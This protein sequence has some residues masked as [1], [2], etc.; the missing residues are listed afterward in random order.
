MKISFQKGNLIEQFKLNKFDYIAHQMNCMPNENYA[1]I[2]HY[3]TQEFPELKKSDLDYKNIESFVYGKYSFLNTQFG[4]IVNLYGQFM[5]GGCNDNSETDTFVIRVVELGNALI[6]LLAWY[7]E[8]KELGI[9]LIASGLAAD[10]TLKGNKTDLEYFKEYIQPIFEK[11]FENT[12]VNIT[13]M[14]L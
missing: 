9:P 10:Q 14:Y 13:V 11:V 2:A 3:L 4:N 12:Q 1:G 5:P 6:G 8:M 7:P